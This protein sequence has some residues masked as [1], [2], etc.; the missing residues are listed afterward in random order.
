MREWQENAC[1]ICGASFDDVALNLDHDHESGHH[2]GLLCT[3]CNQGLGFFRD[4][5]SL[6]QR[7]ISYLW[8]WQVEA[9]A[10]AGRNEE[11][12]EWRD[13]FPSGRA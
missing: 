1:A 9:N 6:L 3:R 4:D 10:M 2:R 5:P 7:A 12:A 11:A 8:E 13:C